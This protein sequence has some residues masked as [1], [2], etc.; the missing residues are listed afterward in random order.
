MKWAL[1]FI[2]MLF[3]SASSFCIL[4]FESDTLVLS[5]VLSTSLAAGLV[6]LATWS[7]KR[8]RQYFFSRNPQEV[9]AQQVVGARWK[10]LLRGLLSLAFLMFWVGALIFFN[11][12]HPG[13][14]FS[15]GLRVRDAFKIKSEVN[16]R[17]DDGLGDRR[18][19]T[20]IVEPTWN[21]SV[22]NIRL[23]SPPRDP[24]LERTVKQNFFLQGSVGEKPRQG[25]NV[26]I[27]ENAPLMVE[28]LGWLNARITL[29]PQ[30]DMILDAE[31]LS[32][33]EFGI[34]S[35]SK[36]DW[37]AHDASAQEWSLNLT[38]PKNAFLKAYPPGLLERHPDKDVFK[39]ES[40][41]WDGPVE[42][43]ILP[44]W[45]TE[46]VR[47]LASATLESGLIVGWAKWLLGPAL[48]G[49]AMLFRET[50]AQK[51]VE[52]TKKLFSREKPK[53]LIIRP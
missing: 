51:L 5:L 38:L 12:R 10:G 17:F 11:I 44:V 43:Y 1:G 47:E 7:W 19:E 45:R 2:L 49:I 21:L 29:K 23:G 8:F 16:V 6:L 4:A 22:V 20:V 48:L 28:R 26:E 13:D 25:V 32:D 18:E 52:R 34:K 33:A 14:G 15:N 46:P 31:N 30:A 27:R 37:V 53:S 35:G 41:S 3:V 24:A 42:V 50:I 39:L 36:Q 9:V 40:R